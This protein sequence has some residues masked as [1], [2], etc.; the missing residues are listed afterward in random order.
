MSNSITVYIEEDQLAAQKANNYSLYLAKKVNESFTVIWQSMGALA[1]VGQPSYQYQNVFDIETPSYMVN[2][3][4]DPCTPGTVTFTSVGDNL[5]IDTGQETTLQATGIFTQAVNGGGVGDILIDNKLQGN[6]K[7]ILL[8][9]NGN[10]I[11]VNTESGM[12]IGTATVTP[13]YSYQ[14]WFGNL[15]D[16][17]SLIAQNVS[18]PEVITLEDGGDA[19]VTYNNQ[20]AWV[21]GVPATMLAGPLLEAMERR[22]NAAL[23]A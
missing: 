11:W 15:Q 8:D 7:E 14:L 6:P 2:F 20:G 5:A 16:T 22:V 3:T 18:N 4:N 17:G 23:L 1:T 19:T 21:N 13:L 12:N 9:A 10:N